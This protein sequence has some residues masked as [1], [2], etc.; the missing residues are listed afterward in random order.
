MQ[1][2]NLDFEAGALYARVAYLCG[3]YTADDRDVPKWNP[4]DFFGVA[5]AH[6]H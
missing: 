2:P 4:S 1:Q 5:F 6:A 3:L